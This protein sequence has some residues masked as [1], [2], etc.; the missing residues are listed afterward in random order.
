MLP[1]SYFERVQQ[2]IQQ[3]QNNQ[4]R[5]HQQQQL[6]DSRK[7]EDCCDEEVKNQGGEEEGE[8]D[9]AVEGANQVV[10]PCCDDGRIHRGMSLLSATSVLDADDSRVMMMSIPDGKVMIGRGGLSSSAHA[11]AGGCSSHER[12]S[13]GGTMMSS[14]NSAK[15]AS[16]LHTPKNKTTTTTHKSKTTTRKGKRGIMLGSRPRGKSDVTQ[17][18]IALSTSP[19]TTTRT[20][21][22]LFLSKS[23]SSSRRLSISR[24]HSGK[25]LIKD[26]KDTKREP[27]SKSAIKAARQNNNNNNNHQHHHGQRSPGRRITRRLSLPPRRMSSAP[28]NLERINNNKQNQK[29][30]LSGSSLNRNSSIKDMMKAWIGVNKLSVPLK[31]IQ[32]YE[33]DNGV[34]YMKVEFGTRE[35]D[36]FVERGKI[37]AKVG[38]TKMDWDLFVA[39]FQTMEQKKM[40]RRSI[41]TTTSPKTKHSRKTSTAGV[42]KKKPKS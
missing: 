18:S 16:N 21:S 40:R 38:V 28:L 4:H 3:Q 7:E 33:G 34:E 20:A 9:G 22:A 2:C 42:Q 10:E 15:S 26:H 13:G 36:L 6:Q 31:Q 30:R 5:N 8:R 35:I 19:T 37:K 25:L 27:T 39:R 1:E 17:A 23:N 24:S 14:I 11:A 41:A 32:T 12:A 29:K